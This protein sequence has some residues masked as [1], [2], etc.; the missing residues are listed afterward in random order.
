[1]A[2]LENLGLEPGQHLIPH[3]GNLYQP[4]FLYLVPRNLLAGDGGGVAPQQP[5]QVVCCTWGRKELV[6]VNGQQ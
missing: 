4:S 6:E 1:M 2:E 3:H 5:G